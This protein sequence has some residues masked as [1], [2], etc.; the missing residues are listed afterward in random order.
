MAFRRWVLDTHRWSGHLVEDAELQN[1]LL[2]QGHLVEF[3]PDALLWAE[4]PDSPRHATSQ[5]ER[6][7]RGRIDVARR[8]VPRL[9][10]GIAREP[11][12]RVAYTDAMLDHLTPPLS[13]L[14]TLHLAIAGTAA[15][16][17]AVGG[18]SWRHPLLLSATAL[19]GIGGHA[20][21][22]LASVRAPSSQYRALLTAPPH[23]L[24]KSLLWLRVLVDPTDRE[25]VR[26]TRNREAM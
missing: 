16:G 14:A 26:T 17:R 6:W 13:A 8:Y 18:R 3:V 7:E 4:M 10:A 20:F 2:L 15:V 21:A 22:G 9:L 19:A 25:W 23:V 24:W 5:N 11:R 12:R 1:E